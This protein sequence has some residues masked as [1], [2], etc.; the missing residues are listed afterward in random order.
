MIKI[1]ISIV[2]DARKKPQANL[3]EA[4]FTNFLGTGDEPMIQEEGIGWFD[5]RTNSFFESD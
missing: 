3:N 4:S 1:R 5:E 2:F